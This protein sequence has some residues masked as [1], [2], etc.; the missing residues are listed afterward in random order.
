MNSKLTAL[1]GYLAGQEGEEVEG[2]RRELADP[3]S[4]ASQFLTAT[5]KLSRGALGEDV[6]KWLRIGPSPQFPRPDLAPRQPPRPPAPVLVRALPWVVAG[7]VA[8]LAFLLWPDCREHCQALEAQLKTARD[9]VTRLRA[10]AARGAREGEKPAPAKALPPR[11][12]P[13]TDPFLLWLDDHEHCRALEAELKT[14]HDE[15]TRLKAATANRTRGGE[16]PALVKVLPPRTHPGPDLLGRL[17]GELHAAEARV[18]ILLTELNQTRILV[19]QQQVRLNR[20]D[21]RERKQ[22]ADLKALEDQGH[23]LRQERDASWKR[24]ALLEQHLKKV[25]KQHQAALK[26]AQDQIASLKRQLK[27]A[28]K[29]P[30]RSRPVPNKPRRRLP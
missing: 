12:E 16:K 27:K 26:D 2:V 23:S 9:E 28:R 18:K 25:R 13:G 15:I 30:H 29:R 19:Q 10:A 1:V 11:T 6:L 17:E 22:R 7:S 14:A 3:A 8:V 24:A 21:H 5:Q 4:E 20:V